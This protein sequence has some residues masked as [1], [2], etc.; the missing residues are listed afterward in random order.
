VGLIFGTFQRQFQIPNIPGK[1]PSFA[2]PGIASFES[3]KLDESQREINDYGVLSYLKSTQ[4]FDFQIAGFSRFSSLRFQPDPIGDIVFGGI[5]HNAFRRNVAS[6]VQAEGSYRLAADHTLRAGAL[7]IGERSTSETTSVV[8]PV[9]G[10]G[11]GVLNSDGTCT[12]IDNGAKTGWTYSI[13][14]QDECRLTPALT[15]NFGGRFD[16]ANTISNENQILR[17]STPCGRRRRPRRFM[18]AMRATSRRR[19][20]SIFRS[21]PSINSSAPAR[22]RR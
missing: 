5:A 1:T 2:V 13:F 11:G 4:D 21:P 7:I 12:V 16:V 3:A 14:R 10:C 15:L 17:A 8:L 19:P 22:N 18:P 20:S 6:G 9:T